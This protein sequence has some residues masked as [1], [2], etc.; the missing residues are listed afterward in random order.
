MV[1]LGTGISIRDPFRRRGPPVLR[2]QRLAHHRNSARSPRARGSDGRHSCVLCATGAADLPR[3][4]LTLALA[5][6]ANVTPVRETLAWHV[7]YLSNVQVFLTET[8]PG[9]ISHLWSLAVEEQFYLIWPWLIVFVPRRWLVPAVVVAIVSAPMFRWWLATEGYRETLLAVLTPGC[10]DSL[11]VGALV[12]LVA[13]LKS[14]ATSGTNPESTA[15]GPRS[16]VANHQSPVRSLRSPV[17]SLGA[18]GF[19]TALLVAEGSGAHLPFGLIALKQTL[20]AIVFAWL[21]FRAAEGFGGITGRVLSAAP[22]VY[23]GRISYGIY[24]AHGFAGDILAGVGI[25]SRALPEPWRFMIL[26]GLTVGLAAVSW[27]LVESPINAMKA[28]FP[29]TPA[30]RSAAPAPGQFATP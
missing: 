15:D 13:G 2:A 20:Q 4:Y 16:A 21:V 22:V 14:R 12:A 1:A 5:W 10:L 3:V 23:I 24:L 18:A 6:L 8:W 19:L 11:G 25:N 27:R 9:S 28:R 17:V 30:T 26:S 29:Y 7:A